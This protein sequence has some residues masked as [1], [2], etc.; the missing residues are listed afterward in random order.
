MYKMVILVPDGTEK[1]LRVLLEQVR[2]LH[3]KEKARGM[4]VLANDPKVTRASAVQFDREMMEGA[5]RIT[6][7]NLIKSIINVS[8]SLKIPTPA[9]MQDMVATGRPMGRPVVKP[10]KRGKL[11]VVSAR[12]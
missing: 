10:V 7:T 11:R 3:R 8:L 4:S 6:L 1:E 5:K 2:D 12:E 9:L